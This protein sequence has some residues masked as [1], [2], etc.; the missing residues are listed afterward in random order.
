[1]L[2]C[3]TLYKWPDKTLASSTALYI[4]FKSLWNTVWMIWPWILPVS[5]YTSCRMTTVPKQQIKIIVHTMIYSPKYCMYKLS[6]YWIRQT[7]AKLFQVSAWRKQLCYDIKQKPLLPQQLLSSR[8]QLPRLK[9]WIGLSRQTWRSSTGPQAAII[10]LAAADICHQT[11]QDREILPLSL[12]LFFIFTSSSLYTFVTTPAF[13]HQLHF[14][15]ISLLYNLVLTPH[16]CLYI[17]ICN[18]ALFQAVLLMIWFRKLKN[19]ISV[20]QIHT[21]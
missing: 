6:V 15:M 12:Q 16:V 7:F 17:Y 20:E 1:M 3:F 5:S 4:I 2:A 10:R 19:C 13:S 8:Q 9:A 11:K 18:C 21:Q 14:E